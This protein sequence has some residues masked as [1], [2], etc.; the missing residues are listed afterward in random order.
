MDDV[1]QVASI[2]SVDS[3]D[4]KSPVVWMRLRKLQGH[5]IWLGALYNPPNPV[6]MLL[7]ISGD[8][9]STSHHQ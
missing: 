6:T 7:T 2:T 8:P 3:M 4:T 1:R 9:W 5:P